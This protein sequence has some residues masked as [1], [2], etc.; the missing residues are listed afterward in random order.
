[1]GANYQ[2][3]WRY[4]VIKHPGVPL[5]SMIRGVTMK[6]V[7][8]PS[9]DTCPPRL[10]GLF[11]QLDDRLLGEL[12]AHKTTNTYKRGQVIFYEGNNPFSV[13]CIYSGRVK[14]F[15]TDT[16]GHQHIVRLAG[17][18]DLLGYRSLLAHEPY[19]A[20]A[21]VIEDAVICCIDA[22][23]FFALVASQPALALTVI[24]KLAHELRHAETWLTSI[25]HHSVR[26]R[27]AELL[28]MLKESYGKSTA[29]GTIIDLR[30][31]REELAEMIGT[32]QES[33][34]RLLTDLKDSGVIAV[35]GRSITIRD[36][37]ALLTIANVET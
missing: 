14:L 6:R 36:L 31:S 12:T 33:A 18:G 11:C 17:P 28:L 30:L 25:A 13:Y 19:H 26:E 37:D 8:Q 10:L 35:Q 23:A 3:S 34:I 4:R 22:K 1:M 7:A 27:M 5:I 29:D 32:T 16:D 20:S 24:K 2:Q 9:C 15:K 21:E